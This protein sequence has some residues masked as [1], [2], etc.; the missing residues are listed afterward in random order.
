[1]CHVRR[2]H[3]TH[4]RLREG[5]IKREISL[6]HFCSSRETPFIRGIVAPERPNVIERPRLAAHHPVPAREV[7]IDG[8]FS[9]CLEDRFVKAGRQ[10]IDEIDVAREFA[11]LLAGHSGRN[12]DSQMA[13]RLMDRVD[14]RLSVRSDLVYIL[15]EVENP[16]Q[17]LLRRRDVVTLRAEDDD[18]RAYVAKVEG[19]AIRGSYA[20]RCEIVADEQLVDDELNFL[21]VEG[22][23]AAPPAF[24]IKV[25][26]SFAVDLGV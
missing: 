14:D 23:V 11:V 12:E 1:V 18:R 10:H 26:R 17:R 22:D 3:G 9:L 15:V 19:S 4:Q 24:E 21:T 7:G 25:A 2:H 20:T 13:Y 16:S 8:I 6:R 5:A